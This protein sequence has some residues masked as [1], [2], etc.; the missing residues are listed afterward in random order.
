MPYVQVCPHCES[1]K[2]LKAVITQRSSESYKCLDC[3]KKFPTPNV[4]YKAWRQLSNRF[5]K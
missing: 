5:E 4:V 3:K 2:I 1:Q